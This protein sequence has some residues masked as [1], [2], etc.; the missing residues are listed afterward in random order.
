M[1]ENQV[2]LLS[3]I[4]T[5]ISDSELQKVLQDELWAKTDH[6]LH[7]ALKQNGPDKDL[8]IRQ[9]NFNEEMTRLAGQFL[10]KLEAS[11]AT[12][13]SDD[14]LVTILQ[15]EATKK[16]WMESIAPDII[17][18][19][20]QFGVLDEDTQQYCIVE[21]Y[22]N[23]LRFAVEGGVNSGPSKFNQGP[24]KDTKGKPMGKPN[25]QKQKKKGRRR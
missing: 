7:V 19:C 5:K 15:L 9:V 22:E 14:T 16:E 10:L 2:Q 18:L 20:K 21:N 3:D 12:S 1:W 11:L 6:R 25:R 24:K 4:D 17:E 23:L 8:A 13:N